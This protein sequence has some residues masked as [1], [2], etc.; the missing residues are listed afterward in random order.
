M[1]RLTC[2]QAVSGLTTS[3]CAISSLDRPAATRGRD[4]AF[5]L[6]Q[7]RQRARTISGE[8]GPGGKGFDQ[9]PGHGRGQQRLAC[10]DHLD[11]VQQLAGAG[12][13]DQVA[14]GTYPQ[15][16]EDLLVLLLGAQHDDPHSGQR[17]VGDV[18]D[19]RPRSTCR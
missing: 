15:H 19:A 18:A 7:H 2:V 1:M 11:G 8:L 10:G 12:V 5:P 16:R 17:R 3:R 14:A 13:L 9:P 6:G 4:L